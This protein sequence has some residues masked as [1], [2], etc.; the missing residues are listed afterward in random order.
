VT[1]REQ[2]ATSII[3]VVPGPASRRPISEGELRYN[4]GRKRSG[5]RRKRK[6]KK[7]EKRREKG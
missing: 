1:A 6:V 5:E 3:D 2:P 4:I 7:G